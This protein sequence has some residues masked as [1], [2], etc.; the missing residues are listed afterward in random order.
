MPQIQSGSSTDI[1][2]I[3][4]ISKAARVTLYDTTG[5]AITKQDRSVISSGVSDGIMNSGSDYKISRVLRCSHSGSLRVDDDQLLFNDSCEGA[6]YDSNKWIQSVSGFAVTQTA[7]NGILLNSGNSTTITQ[8]AMHLSHR[9]FPIP[10]RSGL[11]FNSKIRCGNHFT[12][13]VMEFGFGSPT[14]PTNT[15][16]VN[17]ACWRKD[18]TGQYVPVITINTG[19]DILGTAI[20]N[21]TFLSFIPSTDYAAFEVQLFDDHAHFAIYTQSGVLVNAQDLDFSGTSS[22]H[23]SQTHL[24]AMIRNYNSGTTTTAVQTWVQRVAVYGIDGVNGRSFREMMSGQ[25]YNS[26]TSPTTYTQTSNYVNS[27]APVSATLSNTAASYVTLGGQFQFVP[28]TGAE[29]DYALFAFLVPSP[30]TFFMTGVIINSWVAGAL[31]VTA[32]VLQWG[33]GLNSNGVSLATGAPYSPMK[34]ALGSQFF[35]ITAIVGTTSPDITWNPGTPLACQPNRYVH[36]IVKMPVGTAA[37][38]LIRGTVTIDG[39]F[40]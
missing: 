12:G 36:V 14:S 22:A 1:L 39:W 4:P 27:T 7:A 15:S 16:I 5:E 37:T 24:Q 20:S 10:A 23:F 18:G 35:P 31:G 40:E 13:N 34:A 32:S 26:L 17:G 2:T 25:G 29:T 19:G 9:F 38:G 21:A 11:V 6:V 28:V 30:M 33:I 3:D 8:G